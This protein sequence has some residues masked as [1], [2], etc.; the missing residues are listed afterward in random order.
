MGFWVRGKGGLQWVA[1]HR[2]DDTP[3]GYSQKKSHN[4]PGRHGGYEQDMDQIY[5]RARAI[6][7]ILLN[8][9]QK[10]AKEKVYPAAAF[11]SCRGIL[12]L[13]NKY[14][15]ERLVTACH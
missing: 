2:R 10:V 15:L 12:A 9:L 4:L 11:R 13:E 5:E 6:D 14:S 8:Y 1:S 3:Y 7:N